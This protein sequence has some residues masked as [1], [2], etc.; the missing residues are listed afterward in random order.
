MDFP[1]YSEKLPGNACLCRNISPPPSPRLTSN[2]RQPTL[3]IYS[4]DRSTIPEAP[5]HL[6]YDLQ[7]K[8]SQLR[9][10]RIDPA[11]RLSNSTMLELRIDSHYASQLLRAEKEIRDAMERALR[12]VGSHTQS[13]S[14]SSG[15]VIAEWVDGLEDGGDDVDDES[16]T[17]G[18][19][20]AEDASTRVLRVGCNC[21]HGYQKSVAFVEEL[22]SKE[23][24]KGWLIQLEHRNLFPK[25]L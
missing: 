25:L 18:E 22:A 21:A 17:S 24:P 23:W 15:E 8:T 20:D 13:S 3:H 14:S 1:S 6:N 12:I 2:F 9:H 10:I 7:S 19:L 4:Y 11:L 5:L 16:D